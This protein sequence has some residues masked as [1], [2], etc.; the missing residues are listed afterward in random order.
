MSSSMRR[1]MIGAGVV[2]AA[3]LVALFGRPH[4]VGRF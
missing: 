4:A 2:A 1:T 3:L